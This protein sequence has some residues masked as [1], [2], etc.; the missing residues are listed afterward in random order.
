[1][2]SPYTP[3]P[4][5]LGT[6]T[7]PADG[8]AR[9]AAV[10]NVPMQAIADGVKFAT[11]R[12]DALADL[13]ALAAITTPANG[14]VRHVTGQG[15]YV[16]QTSATTGVSP[17]RVA[18][19][20][21]TPGG[22]LS[23]HA[24]Q[25]TQTRLVSAS[26]MPMPWVLN[27]ATTPW[28][29]GQVNVPGV[30]AAAATDIQLLNGQL[31]VNI[32]VTTGSAVA[33]A[34]RFPIDQ[35]LVDGATLSSIT[36]RMQGASGHAALPALMPQFGV[37]RNDADGTSGG[38]ANL[39]TSGS[40]LVTDPTALLAT[41]VAAHSVVFTPNQNNVIDKTQYS[42]SLIWWNEGSTNSIVG[43]LINSFSF[44]HAITDARRS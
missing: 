16:F 36:M 25:T 24:H 29:V 12:G 19:A 35:F 13:T 6:I 37:I 38:T 26:N 11:V 15:L 18:A 8:D 22:W 1:M 23:S 34:L 10:F 40:G 42:Y 21:A 43:Q 5:T 41:Y 32:S 44:V 17:Y 33:R 39:L 9:N 27:A 3:S 4:V 20:D 7:V 28:T 2:G 31:Q 14:L 30:P